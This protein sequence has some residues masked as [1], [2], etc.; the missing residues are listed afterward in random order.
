MVLS[1]D[2]KLPA[3]SPANDSIRIPAGYH[4]IHRGIYQVTTVEQD[5]SQGRGC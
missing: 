3:Y 1:P 2:G 5:F 4:L